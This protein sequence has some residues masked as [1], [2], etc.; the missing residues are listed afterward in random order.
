[1]LCFLMFGENVYRTM[2]LYVQLSHDCMIGFYFLEILSIPNIIV[3]SSELSRANRYVTV[4]LLESSK[5][6]GRY[7]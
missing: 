2:V 5:R 6:G 1:M 3:R 7:I 4:T